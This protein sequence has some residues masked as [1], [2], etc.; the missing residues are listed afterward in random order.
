MMKKKFGK[1]DF[2]ILVYYLGILFINKLKMFGIEICVFFVI[3]MIFYI[4]F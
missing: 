4:N 2:L 1:D 3:L